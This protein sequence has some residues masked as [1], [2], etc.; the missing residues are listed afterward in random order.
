M[1]RF[2][3]VV[4]SGYIKRYPD[5]SLLTFIMPNKRSGS[6]LARQLEKETDGSIITPRILT[7]TDFVAAVSP[8]VI[9]SRLDLL[10]RLYV[11]Y[12]TL[13]GA[14]HDLEFEK[15]SS[16]AETVL[17]DFNEV[18]MQMVRA[19]ELFKNV[20]DLNELRTDFFTED[21]RRAMKEYFGYVM[22]TDGEG[23]GSFWK[24]FN[25]VP[26]DDEEAGAQ[27]SPSRLKQKF[28]TLWQLLGKLY[29]AFN[30]SLDA[31]GL[32]TSGGAYRKCAE[33][34]E[35]GLEPFAG[36]KLVF[37]GFNALSESERRLL[38]ALRDMTVDVGIGTERKADFIW[39]KVPSVFAEEDDPALRYVSINARTDNFPVPDWIHDRLERSIPLKAPEIEI[40]SV[41]SNVMQ[42]KVAGAELKRI[43][44][45]VSKQEI[46]DARVAVILPDEN[47]L[48]PLLYSLPD[49]YPS[50]NLTMGFPLKHTPVISFAVLLRKLHSRS[51]L[52]GGGAEY[53]FEDVRAFLGH[54]YSQTIFDT[55]SISDLIRECT[56]RKL[57]MVGEKMLLALG[58]EAPAV[59]RYLKPEMPPIEIIEY[60]EGVMKLVKDAMRKPSNSYLRAQVESVYIDT[61]S[62]AL[63]RL[64]DCLSEYDLR[65]SAPGVFMLADRLIAGE[66][67]AFEGDPMGGLQ[68]MGVLETRCLDFDRIVMLSVNER[69]MPRV[70]RSTTYI[71][72][73]LR[74]EFGMPPANYQQEIFA[75][76]FFRVLGRCESA[77]VT[78][79]SRSSDTR[80]PG[81]SRYLLQMKYL[82]PDIT[83]KE[84]EMRFDM[85]SFERKGL[86]YPK[87][88]G[89]MLL[90]A[91]K[92]FSA[93]AL[94][95]YCNCPL[96][97]LFAD[98]LRLKVEREKLETIDAI[99][100]GTIVHEAIERLYLPDPAK[101]GILLKAPEVMTA[102]RLNALLRLK[103]PNGERL[104]ELEAKRSILRNHFHA[105][106]AELD[107]EN[108]RGSAAILSEYIVRF[109]ENIIKADI[110]Q[111]PFRLW[112]CEIKETFPYTLR[113]GREVMLKM[114]IDRL[115]QKGATGKEEPFRVVDYKTGKVHL[116]APEFDNIFDG[117]M[118]A[119]NL[120]QLLLYAELLIYL[121]STEK[122]KAPEGMQADTL[123]EKLEM[124]IY[125][126]PNLPEAEGIVTPDIAGMK[127]K[128]VGKLRELEAAVA[129]G[130][131]KV[132]M[133]RIEALISEILDKEIPFAGEPNAGRCA[134]CD[135]A[136][137]CEVLEMCGKNCNFAS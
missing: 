92:K 106:D 60:I 82:A 120:L 110:E 105:K 33:L 9:D 99:D 103:A 40:I 104:I 56:D 90:M 29:K 61:Y 107:A 83:L 34:V 68:V 128:T 121:I 84:R 135:Y 2:L 129:R 93:S 95:H 63:A 111:A 126:V 58:K 3:E 18:D 118:E 59:F 26:D 133:E 79:D 19:D 62:D 24:H 101:R 46:E 85:P 53:F 17:S 41:P 52:S 97:F 87:D 50:P 122:I 39:D 94:S 6:F 57:I 76:Y 81:M 66:T 7:I 137:Q 102:E 25:T 12:R 65:I 127:I 75:Y 23:G 119:K 86:S 115:D 44:G 1:E 37:V 48:L 16:W 132:F 36:E 88:G 38:G 98:V 112:G 15:F 131:E 74:I 8:A 28:L 5:I 136:L 123:A 117:S 67:V 71:P 20:R 100:L 4:A 80:A 49:E 125:D 42:V 22:E 31:D 91:D 10:F 109:I 13:P 69:I 77:V 130:G 43:A 89:L 124:V 27:K 70:G 51:R 113:D 78:Y 114:V 116:T 47:L 45:E 54:P 14:I 21:Q 134:F 108:L 32:T 73:S 72:N 35:G 55:K 11:C 96:S 64:S 30:A